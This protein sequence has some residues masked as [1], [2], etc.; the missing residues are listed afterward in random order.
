M[1]KLYR[2]LNY[3]SVIPHKLEIKGNYLN[4][5]KAIYGKPTANSKGE[6][7][8][9]F[10]LRSR[11]RPIR[12]LLLFLF[13]GVLKVLAKAIRRGEKASKLERSK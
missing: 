1:G 13:N 6:R 12:L 5:I 4:V 2:M 10:P 9:T 8:K 7:L 11:T 3:I